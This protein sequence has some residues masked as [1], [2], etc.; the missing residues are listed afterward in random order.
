[1]SR[2]AD[3]QLGARNAR[4]ADRRCL[5]VLVTAQIRGAG[6]GR[7][8]ESLHDGITDGAS[9]Q[10]AARRIAGANAPGG[11][12]RGGTIKPR[13]L[14]RTTPCAACSRPTE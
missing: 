14:R 10:A 4:V 3:A 1:M 6:L 9:D 12:A 2:R 13:S 7:L 5:A 8:V 11:M